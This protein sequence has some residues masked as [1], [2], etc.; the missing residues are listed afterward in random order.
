MDLRFCVPERATSVQQTTA[1]HAI[2]TPLLQLS[3][4]HTEVSTSQLASPCLGI[5][6]TIW[7]SAAGSRCI[8]YPTTGQCAAEAPCCSCSCS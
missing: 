3:C 6:E 8:I 1:T 2:L 4:M 7:W 5:P